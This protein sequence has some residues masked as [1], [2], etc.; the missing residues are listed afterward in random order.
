MHADAGGRGLLAGIEMNESRDAS[1]RKFDVHPFFEFPDGFHP[2]VG[3][4][5]VFA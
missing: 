1:F 5:Q 2:A 3:F 4:E